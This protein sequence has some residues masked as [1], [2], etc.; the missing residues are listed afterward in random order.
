LSLKALR[1]ERAI[2]LF[3]LNHCSL[4]KQSHSFRLYRDAISKKPCWKRS[5]AGW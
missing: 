1:Q 4:L 5:P 2:T 3:Q